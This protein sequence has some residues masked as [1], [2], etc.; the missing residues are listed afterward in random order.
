MYYV[1]VGLHGSG[2]LYVVGMTPRA[3]VPL[4][5]PRARST[6][7]GR[8]PNLRMWFGRAPC[9]PR[10]REREERPAAES[11]KMPKGGKITFIY[12]Y[13]Y[14]YIY[15]S[16][17]ISMTRTFGQYFKKIAP[18]PYH[19]QSPGAAAPGSTAHIVISARTICNHNPRHYYGI[20]CAQYKP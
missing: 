19:V 16:P 3:D 15:I 13:I 18:I 5:T 1:R 4:S 8:G 9:V 7:L 10:S 12:T 6:D 11:E 17:I 2:W 20:S 14:M